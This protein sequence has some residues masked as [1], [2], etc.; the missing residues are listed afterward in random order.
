MGNRKRRALVIHSSSDLYGAS[1]VVIESIKTLIDYGHEVV[2]AI[3][4]DGPLVVEVAKLGCKVEVI[5]LATIRRKYFNIKGLFN[6]GAAFVNSWREI[7]RIVEANKIDIIYSNTTGVIIGAFFSRKY[8]L[9]H[10][11]HVHEIILGPKWLLK[12]YGFLM[13]KYADKVIVVS[14]AVREYWLGINSGINIDK[15]YNGFDFNPYVVEGSIRQ[16]LKISNDTLVVGMIARVHFWKGQCYF[17][18]MAN[19]IKQRYGD[20][21]FIMVGDAYPGYEY[22]Y[23]EIEDRI[24]KLDLQDAVINLGYRTDINRILDG[25]DVFILPSILPDPLPTTILEAMSVAKPVV[26]TN[27]GGAPEM[28]MDKRTGF[29]IPWDNAEKAVE[30]IAPLLNND[31]IRKEMGASGKLRVT[32]YFSVGQYKI[33]LSKIIENI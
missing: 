11:W 26:A 19:L 14:E 25:L 5:P 24:K 8:G 9:K 3:S 17:L 7:K 12:C 2:F 23:Q 4:T 20:V 27:H 32:E 13:Q 28:V 1:R 30:I 33:N 6:R 18:E 15:L 16:D 22:L 21:K 29:L 31:T 10:V